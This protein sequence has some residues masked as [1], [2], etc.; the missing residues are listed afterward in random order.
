ME[1]QRQEEEQCIKEIMGTK[2]KGSYNTKQIQEL[3][4]KK[5]YE[6]E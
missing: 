1:G 2:I 4:I 5:K 6:L 3:W